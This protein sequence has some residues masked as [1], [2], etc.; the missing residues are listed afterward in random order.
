MSKHQKFFRCSIC[1]NL[2]GLV[3][4]G[5]GPLVCCGKPMD[6]LEA[7]T[8][9]AAQEKHVPVISVEG[10]TVHVC[11]GSTPHPMGEEHS[12]EWIYLETSKGGQRKSLPKNQ[13]PEACFALTED[14]EP[15][16]AFAY[17]NLHGLWSAQA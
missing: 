10:N 5:G 11:V 2:V 12:I 6:V 1:G 8:T 13:S 4:N 16:A 3:H 17:C 7:N 9:D 14:E 15:R